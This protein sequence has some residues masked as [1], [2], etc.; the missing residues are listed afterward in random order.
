MQHRRA[1]D[2]ASTSFGELQWTIASTTVQLQAFH[3][4]TKLN[5]KKNENDVYSR[6][7]NPNTDF[8]HIS[9]T[10]SMLQSYYHESTILKVASKIG[11]PIHQRGKLSQLK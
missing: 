2:N 3:F 7:S 5:P 11:E 10:A 8:L 6:I 9:C 4:L 1:W